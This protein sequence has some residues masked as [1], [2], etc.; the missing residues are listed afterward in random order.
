MKKIKKIKKIICVLLVIST[1]FGLCSN[2][3]RAEK[4]EIPFSDVYEQNWYYDSVKYVYD[5]GLMTGSDGKFNPSNNVT[6]AQL[7]TTLYRLAGSPHVTD[8]SGFTDFEDVE[9]AKY[10]TEAVCWA[11]SN[12]ITT[13][14]NGKFDPT[15][16]LTRQQMAAF[17]FRYAEV[18]GMDTTA[19][20]D[21]SSMV[22][23]DKLSSYAEEPMAWAVGEGL[24]SGSDV[25]VNGVSAKDLNPRGFTTRSQLATILM[26]FCENCER[27]Q[28]DQRYTVTFD[29]NGGSEVQSQSVEKGSK[30]FKPANPIKKGFVFEN[31]YIDKDLKELYDFETSVETNINLYAKWVYDETDITDTDNDSLPEWVEKQFGA[32]PTKDDTDNDGL[33]DYVE[34]MILSTDPALFDTDTNGTSDAEE[35]F[36]QDGIDNI[37][38]IK[39]GTNPMS[40]D[41]DNDNLSDKEE[42]IYGT[43]PLVE[44]TDGDGAS[45]GLEITLATNPLVKNEKFDIIINEKF[46]DTVKPTVEISL[47]GEQVDTLKISPVSDNILFSKNLPGYLGCA[48]DFSVEGKFDTA[49]IS[50]EF[51]EEFLDAENFKPVIYY[52][53]ENNQRLEELETSVVNNVASAKVTHFSTYIL[54]NKTDFDK[55]WETEIKVP[56]YEGEEQ[57]NGLDV[58]LAIDSSGSMGDNDKNGL[59]KTAAKLFVEKLGEND[60]AAVVDFDSRAKVVCAI[61]QD[62]EKLNTA[63]DNI[64]SSGGTNLS[65]PVDTAIKI[66]TNDES[67]A[68]KHK[69]II[70][71]TDGQGSYQTSYSTSAIEND[72]QIYTIGLGN[73]VDT[74]LLN[75]IANDTGGRYYFADSAEELLEIY[76]T[77]ASE[78]ID[79]VTDSNSDGISDYYTKLLC[80]GKL[81]TGTGVELFEGIPF[82]K[83][84][85]NDDYDNDGLKNGDEIKVI[86]DEGKVYLKILSS[87][88]LVDTDNDGVL[89]NEDTQP[90]KKG[91]KDDICGSLT[92]VSCYNNEDAAWTSG[93]VFFV[94]TSYI[95][96]SVDF[97]SLTAGWSRTDRSADWSW[98]N[99]QW[100]SPLQ[101]EY[102]LSVN[103]SVA[104]GNGGFD[105]GWF[106][107]GDGSGSAGDASS[108]SGVDEAN[109]VCYN[110]ET[111]KFL[112]PQI[113]YTY[114]VNTSLTEDITSEQ[115][116]RL[117]EYCSRP[118]VNYWSLTHNCAEVACNA[119]NLISNTTVNPYS[120]DF[121][122]GTVA[123]PKGLKVNLRTNENSFENYSF[124]GALYL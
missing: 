99:I 42:K 45:D 23:A 94:Y 104:I 69:F 66:L 116:E 54:L 27:E 38:E 77:T 15:G 48:Y 8:Y 97:S 24:I 2:T 28:E 113:G 17:F 44:D 112:N 25:T 59:R 89:D 1:V 62:K 120:D 3:V 64:D 26:R 40:Y 106:L 53:N 76:D 39:Q 95:E 7:V 81:R 20:G 124:V 67:S 93:H 111:Y 119:W 35:D 82:E 55:V 92:L 56:T 71:L 115:L 110:M 5:K 98:K 65:K 79:Y 18:M 74:T 11:Y 84:Q 88:V 57:K 10:Y 21:Y 108:D 70:L 16:N 51:D 43:N 118:N 75:Q 78:T 72:I 90:R 121:M 73:G 30:V 9:L 6:R 114:G 80:E 46:S 107:V 91:L 103:E 123:T 61:T 34:V 50:F 86:S 29:S 87:P 117:L 22:N 68:S 96:D 37:T 14:N 85:E 102:L 32:D 41:S 12:G 19:R 122:W 31:W 100:D 58:V 47:D 60:R 83:V 4:K 13:G 101:N 52:F 109:G 105:K 63:I 36:D 49:V 33:K